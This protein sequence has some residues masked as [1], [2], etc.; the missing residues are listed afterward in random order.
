MVPSSGFSLREPVR[1]LGSDE[2][3]HLAVRR[4][5]SAFFTGSCSKIPAEKSATMIVSAPREGAEFVV[6]N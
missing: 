1:Q 4:L 6:L 2:R 3:D 5:T